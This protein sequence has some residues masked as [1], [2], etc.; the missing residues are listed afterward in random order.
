MYLLQF[1]SFVFPAG[2]APMSQDSPRDIAEQERPRAAGAIVQNGR[3]QPRR[4]TV[5]GSALGFGGGAAA[6]Q[7]AVDAIRGACEAA[8]A[9]QKLFFGR[10]DRYCWAQLVSAS[11]SYKQGDGSA[12]GVDHRLALSFVAGDPFFY[13]NGGPVSPAGLTSAGGTITPAGNAPAFATWSLS[14]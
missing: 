2:F 9:P 7:S 12:Y 11:E 10:S 14:V 13:D 4:L 6:I 3:H 1:G 8:G 5:E